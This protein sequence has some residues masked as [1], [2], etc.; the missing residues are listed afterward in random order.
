[1]KRFDQDS[2]SREPDQKVRSS[3]RVD[4]RSEGRAEGRADTPST[5]RP[6]RSKKDSPKV[7]AVGPLGPALTPS[8]RP[9]QI[10]G[11]IRRA[12]QAELAR[13]VNDPRVQG[14]VSITEVLLT[15]DLAEARV[16]VSVIPED[17]ASLTLSGLRAAAGFLRRRVMDTT[18]IGRVPRILFE[19]D[20][21][22]KRQAKLD[23]AVREGLSDPA[24]EQAGGAVDEG[25]DGNS[26]S[27]TR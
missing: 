2:N 16:Q 20:D 17:R 24:D 1:M 9:M 25:H 12:L 23:A 8:D 22:L 21:R 13:G 26:E 7:R 5:G 4:S 11:E 10:G 19:L 18:R 6:T 15:P 14:M 27:Q 3:G